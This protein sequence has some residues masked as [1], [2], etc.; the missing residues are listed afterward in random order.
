[1]ETK[2]LIIESNT[3]ENAKARLS[4]LMIELDYSEYNYQY[5]IGEKNIGYA[6][7]TI[8]RNN[9]ILTIR[10]NGN[11]GFEFDKHIV[12]Q[13]GAEIES[14]VNTHNDIHW[15]DNVEARTYIPQEVI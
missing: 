14:I 3:L 1:M 7:S 10:G 12:A 8:I 4:D 9:T 13:Y 2:Y 11:F 15:C 5:V 6:N